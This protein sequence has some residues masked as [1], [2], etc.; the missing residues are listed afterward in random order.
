MGKN[1]SA[2][3]FYGNS[4]VQ[5]KPYGI[6]PQLPSRYPDTDWGVEQEDMVWAEELAIETLREGF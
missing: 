6:S 4:L 2:K 5:K 1:A 3:P